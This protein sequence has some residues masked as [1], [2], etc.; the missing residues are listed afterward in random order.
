MCGMIFRFFFFY[1]LKLQKFLNVILNN[2]LF[3]RYNLYTNIKQHTSVFKSD[4]M[5]K[6]INYYIKCNNSNNIS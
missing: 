2:F 5:K 3:N 4:N 6:Y 1:I